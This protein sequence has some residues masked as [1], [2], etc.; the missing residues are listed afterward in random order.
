[1]DKHV[2]DEPD[3][4]QPDGSRNTD[5][6]GDRLYGLKSSWIYDLK[7]FHTNFG[8]SRE[9]SQS[10]PGRNRGVAAPGLDRSFRF[11]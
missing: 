6:A 7:V 10:G 5:V 1:M 4:A 8:C 11:P 3:V 2:V 9:G